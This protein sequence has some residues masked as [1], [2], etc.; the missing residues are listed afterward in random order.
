MHVFVVG[1][2]EPS[3]KQSIEVI[4]REQSGGSHLRLE[5]TLRRLEEAF[6]QTAGGGIAW[7]SV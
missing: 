3:L 7:W 4:E 5:L 6:D 2:A 1:G